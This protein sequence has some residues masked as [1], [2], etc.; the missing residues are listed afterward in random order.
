VRVR[1]A[2]SVSG[3]LV[4]VVLR[5]IA[6]LVG[7][8]LAIHRLSRRLDS[9]VADDR[10]LDA[11]FDVFTPD[12][13]LLEAAGRTALLTAAGLAVALV[14][15]TALAALGRRRRGRLG[16]RPG[17]GLDVAV[18][19]AVTVPGLAWLALADRAEAGGLIPASGRGLEVTAPGSLR[20]LGFWAILIGLAMTPGA[21]SI[22]GH[23]PS[24]NRSGSGSHPAL[25]RVAGGP[26]GRARVGMPTAGLGLVLAL[27][28]TRSGWDGLFDRFIG[29]LALGRGDRLVAL[30]L[31]IVLGGMALSLVADLAGR[32]AA[33]FGERP[34]VVPP[35][36]RSTGWY[37]RAWTIGLGLAAAVAGLAL[38]SPLVD[39]SGT[40][41]A[42]RTSRAIGPQ[43]SAAF[44]PAVV[45]VVVGTGLAAF[46]R[47]GGRLWTGAVD[48]LLALVWWPAA[49]VVPLALAT[50][51]TAEHPLLD[52]AVLQVTGLVLVPPA[53][54][55]MGPGSDSLRD[56]VARL[57]TTVL[58]LAALAA[59]SQILAGYVVALPVNDPTPLGTLAAEASGDRGGSWDVLVPAGAS[60][61]VLAALLALV[62]TVGADRR[63]RRQVTHENPAD[64]DDLVIHLP[65][66]E[67]DPGP[68]PEL[69]LTDLPGPV[70]DQA[71][72]HDIR[73]EVSIGSAIDIEARDIERPAAE[74]DDAEDPAIEDQALEDRADTDASQE[75]EDEATRTIELRPS[76]F[77]TPGPAPTPDEGR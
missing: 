7:A 61:L 11:V 71:E 46:R 12:R 3:G 4:I 42:M 24:W 70:D 52:P 50:A 25:P 17:A 16:L 38:L 59:A 56:L 54:R 13:A 35:G 19:L 68:A 1:R 75:L 37:R 27:A 74:A 65:M 44:L 8:A 31:P 6:L 69:T 55:M 30:A 32:R 64:T 62:A 40:G 34:P 22:V 77:R 39:P 10:F 53:A 26:F 36:P 9:R 66:T 29:E 48:V 21:A 72:I 28:E 73:A 2:L 57:S 45:A 20:L 63:A 76:L 14:L 23:R 5:V 51:A 49:L 18:L 41:L 60:V 47:P 43:L 67:P 58:A 33:R 15:G